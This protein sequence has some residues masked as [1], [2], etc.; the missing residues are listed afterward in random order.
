MSNILYKEARFVDIINFAKIK[1][2]SVVVY[3]DAQGRENE[4]MRNFGV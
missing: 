2:M 4:R 3:V 1:D